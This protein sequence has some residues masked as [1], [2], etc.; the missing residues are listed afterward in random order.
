MTI[1][2]LIIQ[3]EGEKLDFKNKIS[4]CQKIAKTLVAFANTKGGQLLVGVADDGSIKGIKNEEEEKYM[5]MQA[6]QRYCKPAIEPTFEEVYLD[7][8]LVLVVGIAESD[9]KPHYALDEH[10]KWWVY[11]RVN[12]KS[13]LAD[14]VTVDVLHRGSSASGVLIHYTD[15]EKKLLAYL[16][17]HSEPEL[18]ALT[19]H[20]QLSKRQTRRILVNLIL[21]GVVEIH[22]G[23]H[24]EYY[25][26]KHT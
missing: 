16:Q 11:I 13:I 2:T 9:L 10:H 5:L 25:T 7:D 12:D 23:D 14:K 3:G 1:K 8:K 4:N 26:E 18:T 21:A 24:G 20:L 22:H 19:Q 15:H 17:T 6:G